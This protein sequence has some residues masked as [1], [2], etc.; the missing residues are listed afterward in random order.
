MTQKQVPTK[1]EL[2]AR[3]TESREKLERVVRSVRTDRLAVPGPDGWSAK[4]HIA[5]LAAWE[6]SV[7]NLLLGLPRHSALDVSEDDY[8]EGDEDFVNERIR[9]S[10]GRWSLAQVVTDFQTVHDDLMEALNRLKDEDLA[11]PYSDFLP[12]EPGRESGDPIVE[13]ITANTCDHYD[14]HRQYIERALMAQQ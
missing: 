11:R 4:D 14:E 7:V 1:D 12:N 9:A 13:C 2:E 5:H 3:I 10:R 6:R 8:L